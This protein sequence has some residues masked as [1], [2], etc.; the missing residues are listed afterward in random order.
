MRGEWQTNW[1][2]VIKATKA[3]AAAANSGNKKASISKSCSRR[4]SNAAKCFSLFS[5]C[6]SRFEMNPKMLQLKLRSS[7]SLSLALTLD[8]PRT[9]HYS[10]CYFRSP[11]SIGAHVS[12][13]E[14]VRYQTKAL[15]RRPPCTDRFA[16]RALVLTYNGSYI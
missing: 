16:S 10:L 12:L 14:R 13:F 2:G 4:N 9:I 11:A 1:N 3:A 8:L 15:S 6:F 7:L 5:L